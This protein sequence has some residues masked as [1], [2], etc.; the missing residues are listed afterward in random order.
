MGLQFYLPD[1]DG[2]GGHTVF[3][4]EVRAET[5]QAPKNEEVSEFLDKDCLVIFADDDKIT[6]LSYKSLSKMI[7]AAHHMI[8]GATFEEANGL[9]ETVLEA[10]REHGGR[11]V[12]CIFDQ[13]MDTYAEGHVLGTDIVSKLRIRKFSGLIFIRSANDDIISK[14]SY[15]KSGA[16]A[17]LSKSPKPMP[18]LAKEIVRLIKLLDSAA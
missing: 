18:D 17:T 13:N 6:R 4:L 11:N 5:A 12:I 2:E 7:G 15:M 10:E 3:S 14:L 1:G 8:L 16:D 9:V